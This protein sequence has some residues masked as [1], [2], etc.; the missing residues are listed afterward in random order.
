MHLYAKVPRMCVSVVRASQT[1]R[2]AQ[3][4]TAA[5]IFGASLASLDRD[6]VET[7]CLRSSCH[8]GVINTRSLGEPLAASCYIEWN[9]NA[10]CAMLRN[11]AHV[12]HCLPGHKSLIVQALH[13]ATNG[14]EASHNFELFLHNGSLSPTGSDAR[15]RLASH[16]PGKRG[17]RA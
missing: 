12:L 4:C 15:I 2:D 11:A 17:S 10:C 14:F 16:L 3:R 8:S 7:G 9:V 13:V 6:D 5:G 1:K